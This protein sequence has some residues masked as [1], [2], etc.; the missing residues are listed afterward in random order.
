MWNRSLSLPYWLLLLL[1]SSFLICG[2]N[3]K[4]QKSI[5]TKISL[6]SLL[7]ASNLRQLLSSSELLRFSYIKMDAAM[8]SLCFKHQINYDFRVVTH[9]IETH[10]KNEINLNC[11]GF[12]WRNFYQFNRYNLTWIMRRSA[13]EY[14]QTVITYQIQITKID[15]I[16]VSCIKSP[17]DEQ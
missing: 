14:T 4:Q 5:I 13:Q 2:Q 3:I 11:L 15:T 6:A 9:S 17:Y 8:K 10:L 7:I 12:H 16:D 1:F